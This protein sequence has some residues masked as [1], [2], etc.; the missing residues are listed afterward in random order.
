MKSVTQEVFHDWRTMC[1]REHH[2]THLLYPGLQ[3]F[4]IIVSSDAVTFLCFHTQERRWQRVLYHLIQ[5]PP[6]SFCVLPAHLLFDLFCSLL[7]LVPQC[8]GVAV[9]HMSLLQALC[10]SPDLSL[11]DF[12]ILQSV[13][14]LLYC[15]LMRI[16]NIVFL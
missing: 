9:P 8:S 12:C 11:L 6:I 15:H 7:P 16:L 13:L 4:L 5:V 3:T 1:H 10:L 14:V 2:L